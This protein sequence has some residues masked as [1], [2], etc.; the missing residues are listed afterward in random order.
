MPGPSASQP[1]GAGGKRKTLCA[2]HLQGFCNKGDKCKYSH[3]LRDVPEELRRRFEIEPT[4]TERSEGFEKSKDER[5]GA[6]QKERKGKGGKGGGKDAKKEP[7]R[8][9]FQNGT[10]RHGEKCFMSHDPADNPLAG[11]NAEDGEGEGEDLPQDSPD[12]NKAKAKPKAKRRPNGVCVPRFNV[13]AAVCIPRQGAALQARH[14][15]CGARPG[16]KFFGLVEPEG[17]DAE[18][19]ATKFGPTDDGPIPCSRGQ[20]P[21]VAEHMQPKRA[22]KRPKAPKTGSIGQGGVGK[23]PE[24]IQPPGHEGGYI[25]VGS[26]DTERSAQEVHNPR[27]GSKAVLLRGACSPA[28]GPNQGGQNE[29]D[30]NF[31]T[32]DIGGQGGVARYRDDRCREAG[33]QPPQQQPEE[34]TLGSS[35]APAG[36]PAAA[37]TA[38]AKKKKKN[39]RKKKRR[40]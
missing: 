14:D 36:F 6:P 11:A 10:C 32:P 2:Y 37:A 34:R 33:N 16:F 26:L 19:A 13:P 39:K 17:S 22:A 30:R 24:L 20:M 12:N 25:S 4:E 3:D 38:A 40:A 35:T 28:I 5:S 1:E 29:Q 8:F 27:N 31:C 15:E 7:C 23:S 18:E 9:F 21:K